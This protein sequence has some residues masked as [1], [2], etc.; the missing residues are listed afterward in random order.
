MFKERIL[1]LTKRLY[2]KGRAFRIPYGSTIE[3][4]HKGLSISEND[5]FSSAVSLLDSILPDN[6]N[7]S[8]EDASNWERRLGLI[9]NEFVSLE[10]RKAAIKRKMNHPG[11]IKARQNYLYLQ[12][13]LQDAGFDVY[14]HENRFLTDPIIPISLGVFNLG[15]NSL[16]DEINNPNKYGVIDPNT[17]LTETIKLGGFRLGEKQLKGLESENGSFDVI[18]NNIDPE[19]EKDFFDIITISNLGNNRLGG[20]N[21][22]DLFDYE[23]AL[24][25]TFFIGGPTPGSFAVIPADR[26]LELRQLVLKIKP[27][28]TIG[29]TFFILSNDDYSSAYSNAYTSS[30]I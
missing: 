5:A 3:K 29:F 9:V 13:Q 8:S 26:H 17:Y 22:G 10:D 15:E 24:R 12:G 28:Q 25:S 6:D 18:A 21:L 23:E 27:V 30:S 2:P 7:F 20:F 19:S 11:T 4:V 14:V 16:G 1:N